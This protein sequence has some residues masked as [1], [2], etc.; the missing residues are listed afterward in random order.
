[1][2][3]ELYDYFKSILKCFHLIEFKEVVTREHATLA[4]V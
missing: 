1:M 3:F 2:S 4:H